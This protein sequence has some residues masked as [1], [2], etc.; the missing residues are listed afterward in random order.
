MKSGFFKQANKVFHLFSGRSRKTVSLILFPQSR[1]LTR[2]GIMVRE[3]IDLCDAD[4]LLQ[5]IV[6]VL[7]RGTFL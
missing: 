3:Q 5:Q 7:I 4:F 1:V 6:K 2:S